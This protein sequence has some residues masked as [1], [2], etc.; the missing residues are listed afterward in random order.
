MYVACK[1]LCAFFSPGVSADDKTVKDG[2]KHIEVRVG[3]P[4]EL[5]TG[6]TEIQRF[7]LIQWKFGK[8]GNTTSP[9]IAL[10]RL[11]KNKEELPE[12]DVIRRLGDRLKVTEQTRSLTIENSKTTDTGLYKLEIDHSTEHNTKLFFVTVKEL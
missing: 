10:N 12:N 4:I 2:I 9:F 8:L 11:N 3:D 7:D 5:D 1:L 6:V